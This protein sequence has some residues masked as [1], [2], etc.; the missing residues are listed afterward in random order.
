MNATFELRA[1]AAKAPD[2]VPET[3][4]TPQILASLHAKALLAS[5]DDIMPDLLDTVRLTVN[6]LVQL[7]TLDRQLLC[8]IL[9]DALANDAAKPDEF[10]ARE[11]DEALAR[12][13]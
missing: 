6:D 12:L 1:L 11:I 3:T 13:R 2:E 10:W 8:Q 5:V 4:I 7:Q 9:A